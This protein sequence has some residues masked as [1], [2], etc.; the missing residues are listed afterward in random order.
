MIKYDM[1][2]MKTSNKKIL[3]KFLAIIKTISKSKKNKNVFVRDIQVYF[4]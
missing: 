4:S 2:V 3:L 1:F